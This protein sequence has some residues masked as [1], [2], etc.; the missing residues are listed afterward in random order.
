MI[1]AIEKRKHICQRVGD[2]KRP[3]LS[4]SPV[5]KPKYQTKRKNAYHGVDS[6]RQVEKRTERGT[7]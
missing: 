6:K 3:K 2:D 5:D 1:T 7:R 4:P